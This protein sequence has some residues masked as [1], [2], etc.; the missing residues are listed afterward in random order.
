M[1]KDF[2]TRALIPREG[3]KIGDKNSLSGTLKHH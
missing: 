1:Y 2:Q 3:N